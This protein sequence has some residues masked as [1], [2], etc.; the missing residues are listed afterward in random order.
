MQM[1]R[2]SLGEDAII[3]ATREEKG[4]KSVRV[5]AAIEE[6]R[7]IAFEIGKAGRLAHGDDWLQYDDENGDDNKN[8]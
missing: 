3:I 6:D 1:V 8:S 2:D 7:D 4:G 5:T